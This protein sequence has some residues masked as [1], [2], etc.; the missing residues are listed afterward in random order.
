MSSVASRRPSRSP[1]RGRFASSWLPSFFAR[2]SAVFAADT[3]EPLLSS[4]CEASDLRSGTQEFIDARDEIEYI[5]MEV[6][7]KVFGYRYG[8]RPD[9]KR[10]RDEAEASDLSSREIDSAHRKIVRILQSTSDE[11]IGWNAVARL[12]DRVTWALLTMLSDSETDRSNSPYIKSCKDKTAAYVMEALLFPLKLPQ[13]HGTLNQG[14][15]S[16]IYK[17][18]RKSDFVFGPAVLAAVAS[19]NDQRF[20][21]SELADID[22]IRTFESRYNTK[23]GNGYKALY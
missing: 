9:G 23:V 17:M 11:V 5:V 12:I 10:R 20:R 15:D 16:L 3:A 6:F 4:Y 22:V 8:P 19:R 18:V 1:L 7:V 21:A 2:R 13:S 14:G